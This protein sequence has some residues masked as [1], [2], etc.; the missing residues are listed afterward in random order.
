MRI[1]K[2]YILFWGGEFSNFYPYSKKNVASSVVPLNFTLENKVWKTSE[3][4]FMYKKA[5]FFNDTEIAEKILHTE[6]PEDAKKLGRQVKNFN[7]DEWE[8]VSDE[9]MYNGVYAKFSQN[10][11]LKKFILQPI[12]DNKHFVEASPLDRIWGIGLHYSDEL[13][14]D[15]KNWKGQNKLGKILDRVR[16][17]LLIEK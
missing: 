2:K 12:F 6:R 10:E 1:T 8:K 14:D 13:C 9:I 11:H 17:K 3:Q 7:A 5:I 16:Q 4:Y 15:S